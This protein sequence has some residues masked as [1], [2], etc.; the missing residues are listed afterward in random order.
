MSSSTLPLRVLA[1][2]GGALLATDVA[3]AVAVL[4]V[5][6]LPNLKVMRVLVAVV[7]A[8]LGWLVF[9]VGVLALYM[10]RTYKDTMGLPLFVADPRHSTIPVRPAH[11]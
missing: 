8:H 7:L 6:K 10:A 5:D 11:D 2:V 1:Y 9:A 4:A 3:G